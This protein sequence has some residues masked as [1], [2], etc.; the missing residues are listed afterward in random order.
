M[1]YETGELRQ[2]C[3][4]PSNPFQ[5]QQQH[6]FIEAYTQVDTHIWNGRDKETDIHKQT[7]RERDRQTDRVTDRQRDRER[8]RDIY[9]ERHRQRETQTERQRKRER[10][11]YREIDRLKKDDQIV[12]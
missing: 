6:I 2:L 12:I 4:P 3:F 1:Q 9:R 5:Q 8:E 10:K 11:G 7:K